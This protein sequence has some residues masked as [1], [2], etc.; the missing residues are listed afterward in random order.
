LPAAAGPAPRLDPA[1]RGGAAVP[2][3]AGRARRADDA[4]ARSRRGG[5]ADGRPAR[6]GRGEPRRR[7]LGVAARHQALRGG[8]RMTA[9]T[10][11]LRI[12]TLQLR[13][14]AAAGMSYRADLLLEGALALL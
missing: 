8:G 10:R 2:L 11:Y 13:I 7:A 5:G 9:V 3:H 4:L 14:S 1:R 12:A 6:V